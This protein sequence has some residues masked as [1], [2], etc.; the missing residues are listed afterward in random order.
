MILIR[1]YNVYIL[2]CSILV[3]SWGVNSSC[4]K[5]RSDMREYLETTILFSI[6]TD[7]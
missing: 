2:S 6:K 7:L 1:I 5:L 3:H 4:C